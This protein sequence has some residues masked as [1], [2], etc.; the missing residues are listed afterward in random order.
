MANVYHVVLSDGSEYT[1]TTERHH[2]DHTFE[3][4]ARHVLDVIKGAFSG[5]V[6]GL[7]VSTITHKGRK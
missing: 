7:I 3:E 5:V 1:V 4:F 6:A 2:G